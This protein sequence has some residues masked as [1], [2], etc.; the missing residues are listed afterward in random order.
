M[1]Q[2]RLKGA[3]LAGEQKSDPLNKIEFTFLRVSTLIY[4]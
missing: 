4:L 1:P 2:R 3:L